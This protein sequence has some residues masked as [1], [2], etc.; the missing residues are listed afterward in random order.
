METTELARV[1]IALGSNLGD[2]SRNLQDAIE[3]LSP[4]VQVTDQSPI[5]ETEPW[6]YTDQ[7]QFLNQVIA[8]RTSLPPDELFD[9]LKTIE[10]KLGR[11]PAVRFGP[12]LIDLDLL[13]YN[14]LIY[15]S[16]ELTIPHP[17]LQERAFVLVPLAD[18]AP[19]IIHPVQKK[20]VSEILSHLDRSGVTRFDLEA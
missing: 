9:Y 4:K 10:I 6:G 13:F 19:D 3:C 11:K 18:I 5:Y 14:A 20:T 8:G 7:P 1:F 2:R 15:N 17:R 12:R 16:A